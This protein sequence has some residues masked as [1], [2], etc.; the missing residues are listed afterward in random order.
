ERGK[1]GS[2]PVRTAPARVRQ[3]RQG[4]N[5]WFEVVLIEGRNRELRKMFEQIG[6]FVEKIRRVGY[7]PLVLD[8]E[9]GNLRELD[10]QELALLRQAADGTLRTPKSKEVRRR[11]LIDAGQLPTVSPRF[12]SPRPVKPFAAKSFEERPAAGPKDYKP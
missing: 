9:P 6:H 8:Q 10:P 2:A 4:D 5:P 12:S 11:N 7:G 1:P 3:V